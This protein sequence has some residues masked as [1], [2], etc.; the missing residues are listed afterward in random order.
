M[1]SRCFVVRCHIERQ[2]WLGSYSL[3]C[4]GAPSFL[5]LRPVGSRLSPFPTGVSQLPNHPIR[6]ISDTN[7][8]TKLGCLPPH[9]EAN[10]KRSISSFHTRI[11]TG[12]VVYYPLR[13]SIQLSSRELVSRYSHDKGAE[14]N[15][16][17]PAGKECLVRPRKASA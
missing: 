9:S 13:L 11:D 2:G 4:G 1:I 8:Y 12:G 6:Y 17:T 10:I 16:E 5:G 14:G 7:P 3:S 15:G